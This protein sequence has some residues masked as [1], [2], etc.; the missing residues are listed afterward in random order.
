LSF[1]LPI[2]TDH[3]RQNH[4]CQI[5]NLAR[6][7]CHQ[8]A[9]ELGQVSHNGV[10][11]GVVSAEG[12]NVPVKVSFTPE[13]SIL[14]LKGETD[15]HDVRTLALA[16]EFLRVLGKRKKKSAERRFLSDAPIWLNDHYVL[17]LEIEKTEQFDSS[18]DDAVVLDEASNE[19]Q[20]SIGRETL[21]KV[22]LKNLK[23]LQ[24]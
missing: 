14:E 9:A 12:D 15:L 23:D 11:E 20:A 5:L 13:R 8:Q 4:R 17:D 16:L 24:A 19:R 10:L 22:Q 6:Q 18:H 21:E 3:E 1:N 7:L 2:T